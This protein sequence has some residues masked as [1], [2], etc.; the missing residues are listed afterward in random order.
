MLQGF[1]LGSNVVFQ[2]ENTLNKKKVVVF[3]D[4]FSEYRPQYITG[5]LA[6]TFSEVHFV[7]T[8]SIDYDYVKRE[9]PDIVI[10]E[11]VERFMPKV[12][13]DSFCLEDHVKN[14]IRYWK[15]NEKKTYFSKKHY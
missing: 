12:P 14:Q 9:K 4:S 11:I 2:N 10:T 13:D 8:T 1:H 3:G 15:K 6:E 5:A 7:W